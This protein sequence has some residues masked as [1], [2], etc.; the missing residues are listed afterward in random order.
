MKFQLFQE[1]RCEIIELIKQ[2]AK[3]NTKIAP[4]ENPSFAKT[5]LILP[6]LSDLRADHRIISSIC[7]VFFLQRVS[8]RT[9]A[10]FQHGI[11]LAYQMYD[12]NQHKKSSSNQENQILRKRTFC[13]RLVYYFPYEMR[14]WNSVSEP[15]T[16][17]Q[18]DVHWNSVNLQMTTKPNR[19]ISLS[20]FTTA[21]VT[22][23][24]VEA[25]VRSVAFKIYTS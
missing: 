7:C 18:N 5:L 8:G 10:I 15:Q 2:T 11:S 16:S 20:H 1:F 23:T 17:A 13:K 3:S 12:L 19:C 14:R 21:A 6:S 22:V 24:A 25:V 4:N 9:F